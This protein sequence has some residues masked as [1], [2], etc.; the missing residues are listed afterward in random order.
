MRHRHSYYGYGYRRH[1]WGPRWPFWM[2]GWGIFFLISTASRWTWWGW[3][4]GTGS[5]PQ[6]PSAPV[7]PV[8]T[9]PALPMG[10]AGL[11]GVALIVGGIVLLITL[12]RHK[13]TPP[14]IPLS[15]PDA[16]HPTV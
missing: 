15:G 2:V 9:L 10:F 8:L 4:R 13:E 14:E 11:I 1:W 16:D 12:P 5:T 3:H 7:L 6:A